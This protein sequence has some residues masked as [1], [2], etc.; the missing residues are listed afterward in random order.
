MGGCIWISK[1]PGCA[2]TLSHTEDYITTKNRKIRLPLSKT[3]V[4][5]AD[6]SSWTC[7]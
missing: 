7:R 1:K 4:K 5:S 3:P 6:L 2:P